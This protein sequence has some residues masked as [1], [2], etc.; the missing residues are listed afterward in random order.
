[1]CIADFPS[2]Y[3]SKKAGDVS[4]EPDKIKSYT[5][6]V[7]NIDDVKLN[8]NIIVLRNELGEM[9]NRSCPCII[10]F[11]KLSKLTSPEERY[12]KLNSYKEWATGQ[13]DL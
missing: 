11:D 1:M 5:V 3:I 7:P 9:R 8:S 2:I 4:V 6:L 10:H 13:P 12:L